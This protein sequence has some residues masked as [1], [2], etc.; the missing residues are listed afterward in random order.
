MTECPVAWRHPFE[1][2]PLCHQTCILLCAEDPSPITVGR[3][4]GDHHADHCSP[5]LGDE[6]RGERLGLTSTSTID[7]IQRTS[8]I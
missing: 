7:Q 5:L 1:W 3:S 6:S 4:T 8:Q 2:S